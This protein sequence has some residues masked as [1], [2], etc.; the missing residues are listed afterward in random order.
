MSITALKKLQEDQS[1]LLAKQAAL[2]EEIRQAKRARAGEIG[3]QF[4]KTDLVLRSNL[5]IQG[6]IRFA[7]MQPASWWEEIAKT[8]SGSFRRNGGKPAARGAAAQPPA[9][10]NPE[11]AVGPV[12]GDAGETG[13]DGAAADAPGGAAS[14]H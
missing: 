7:E 14:A 2:D 11:P 4:E 1:A 8:G 13:T 10:A 12:N 6:L 3:S 5:E 9:A